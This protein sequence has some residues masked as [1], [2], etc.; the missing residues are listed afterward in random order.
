MVLRLFSGKLRQFNWSNIKTIS[1]I[2]IK[3]IKRK[4]LDFNFPPK[5][6]NYQK[7]Y[8]KTNNFAFKI[9][10]TIECARYV[11]H[12]YVHIVLTASRSARGATARLLLLHLGGVVV[13]KQPLLM[14]AVLVAVF[15]QQFLLVAADGQA[16]I[17]GFV[18]ERLGRVAVSPELKYKWRKE[19]M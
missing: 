6:R 14:F 3:L 4:A 16:A 1:K 17:G 2:F 11:Y 18:V 13:L 9:S 10:S 7:V 15:H 5:S 8:L 19:L 12:K